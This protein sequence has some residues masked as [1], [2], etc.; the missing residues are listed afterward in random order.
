MKTIRL[1][2]TATS[3]GLPAGTR[4]QLKTSAKVAGT[5]M[6]YQHGCSPARLGLFPVRLDDGIWQTCHT[7][8]VIV[9]SSPKY[10]DQREGRRHNR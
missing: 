1:P 2:D 6:S 8:D 9:L 4:V 10:P 3:P 7:S 5:V